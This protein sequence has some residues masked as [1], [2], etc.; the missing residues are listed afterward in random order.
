MSWKKFLFMGTSAIACFYCF[1]LDDFKKE[2]V[3]PLSLKQIKTSDKSLR[4]KIEMFSYRV[5]KKAEEG[6]TFPVEMKTAFEILSSSGLLYE[7]NQKELTLSFDDV[8]VLNDCFL[9]MMAIPKCRTLL[10]RLNYP[11]SF[12]IL[13]V[14]NNASA[15][16]CNKNISVK[17]N[18]LSDVGSLT[19]D[20]SHEFVHA[21]QDQQNL[22]Q[23]VGFSSSN[24]QI[25]LARIC[26]IETV[27]HDVKMVEILKQ[28]GFD[29]NNAHFNV[30]DTIKKMVFDKNPHFSDQEI[31]QA[32][33]TLFIKAYWTNDTSEISCFSEHPYAISEWNKAY[34][35]RALNWINDTTK[36]IY[37]ET[38]LC[39]QNIVKAY[40]DNMEVNLPVEFFWQKS[41]MVAYDNFDGSGLL[42]LIKTNQNAVEV[43][44]FEKKKLLRRKV[45]VDNVTFDEKYDKEHI[46]KRIVERKL[47]FD[48]VTTSFDKEGK[49][50]SQE[51]I[52]TNE[53]GQQ[54]EEIIA[55]KKKKFSCLDPNGV[56]SFV[57][58]QWDEEGRET[59]QHLV[60]KNEDGSSVATTTDFATY[61]LVS[62][63]NAQNILQRVD[64][65]NFDKINYTLESVLTYEEMQ[66][67]KGEKILKE[68]TQFANGSKEI[69]TSINLKRSS[70]E[71]Y[72]KNNV[73]INEIVFNKNGTKTSIPYKNG[74]KHGV[75]VIMN[76][77]DEVLE[78][79]YYL[80][81][82]KVRQDIYFERELFSKEQA[83]F[84]K[85]PK[86][87]VLSTLI[88]SRNSRLL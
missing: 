43:R 63:F 13:S 3:L 25:L 71:S 61:K 68:I 83:V 40:I 29:I 27:L 2:T 85:N 52:Y 33:S 11:L 81:D 7:K 32:A 37:G 16:Y 57:E 78:K 84:S 54:I 14:T 66:N 23:L 38:P 45:I 69:A 75:S 67:E 53:K 51:H 55:G 8:K 79:N 28:S 82:K 65:F 18:I 15:I 87:V 17:E 76:G 35:E 24:E 47:P 31:E 48:K 86:S 60:Q 50:L 26:E 49:I 59:Y 77:E 64:T 88:N 20:M 9:N 36:V 44:F 4:R 39:M 62:F 10:E 22:L 56:I 74:K 41:S 19:L 6:K 72:D 1:P 70:I 42:D 12:Q 58:K 80:D 5:Q 34:N 21:Y 73:K 30:Y 46:S